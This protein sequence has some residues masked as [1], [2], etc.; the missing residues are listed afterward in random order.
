MHVHARARTCMHEHADACSITPSIEEIKLQFLIGF[1]IEYWKISVSTFI[2]VTVDTL[3]I[4]FIYLDKYKGRY[5]IY[6]YY[7]E[8]RYTG[9]Y[10]FLPS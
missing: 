6:L 5:C 7:C 8:G 3:I 4:Q 9:N 2:G 10:W 1:V